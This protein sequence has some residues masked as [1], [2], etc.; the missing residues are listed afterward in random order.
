[1]AND[2]AAGMR[3]LLV[4]TCAL[5]MGGCDKPATMSIEQALE[6]VAEKAKSLDV[7]VQDRTP[8][9]EDTGA[10]FRIVYP[11]PAG[12]RAG[13][14]RFVVEKSSGDFTEIRIER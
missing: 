3:L 1:M 4:T 6:R 7:P 10:A 2:E 13:E 5:L 14:W 12:M 8:T 11:P 9:I